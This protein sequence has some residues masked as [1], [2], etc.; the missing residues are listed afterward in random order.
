MKEERRKEDKD[1][2]IS[3]MKER[4]RKG[5]KKGK[6]VKNYSIE[7]KRMNEKEERRIE[8]R[9]H[10]GSEMG[11]RKWKSNREKGVRSEWIKR[12]KNKGKQDKKGKKDR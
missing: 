9:D 1:C 11:Q 4:K 12:G 10:R 8:R 3:G 2:G 6:R 7:W 5:R